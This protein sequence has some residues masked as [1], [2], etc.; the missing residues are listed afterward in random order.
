M[1]VRLRDRLGDNGGLV[2]GPAVLG[3]FVVALD[4]PHEQRVNSF[5]AEA[6]AFVVPDS[7]GRWEVSCDGDRLSGVVSRPQ[8]LDP[9][10]ASSIRIVG[11]NASELIA[12]GG[13]WRELVAQSPL[14]PGMSESADI[15]P[16][17]ELVRAGLGH[18][19]EVC[20]RPRA[21]LRVEVERTLVG[22]ARRVPVHAPT[23][24]AAHTEDWERPTLRSV[25]PRRILAEVREDQLD[26]YENRVAVR[27]V[28][29]LVVY[30]QARVREV[31]RALGA[32]D[33]FNDRKSASNASHWRRK[34]FFELWGA[35]V[36][37]DD[38][39]RRAQRTLSQL[40]GLLAAVSGLK[41]SR[42]YEAVPRRASVGTTLTLTNILTDDPHYRQVAELWRAWARR[43]AA[44]AENARGYYE[45]MQGVCRAFDRFALLL[46]VRGLHQLGFEPSE[47][48]APLS[49]GRVEVRRGARSV[50][51][52]W[53][54]P[55]GS[56][57]VSGD[58]VQALHIVPLCSSLATLEPE[59]L[60]SLVSEA[61]DHASVDTGTVVLFPTPAATRSYDRLPVELARRLRSLT[62]DIGLSGKQRVGFLSASPWDIDSVERVARQLRWVTTAPLFRAF[63]GKVRRLALPATARPYEWLTPSGDEMLVL[64]APQPHE[65]LPAADYVRDAKATL[66]RLEG[67]RE[68]VAAT[69]RDSVRKGDATREKNAQKASLAERI[70]NAE[71]AVEELC[72]FESGLTAAIRL[73]TELLA[74]PI[75]GS[76]ADS[77][78]AFRGSSEH[79]RCK[80][81]HCSSTWET[82]R[83]ADCG[84]TI[85]VLR[86]A[87][88]SSATTAH[89]PGWIDLTLGCDVLAIPSAHSH[90]A[91]YV[92]PSCG[93]N[94]DGG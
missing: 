71:R 40:T 48:D 75:C 14:A 73:A 18:L 91:S 47:P 37:A 51:L 17:D 79:F 63:P 55:D 60:Q 68:A 22:R 92:C 90:K 29:H 10:D 72:Q 3:R 1:S 77:R 87:D 61:D 31:S 85:P 33:T 94:G 76:E 88:S 53:S 58:Y 81:P 65:V 20:R 45:R 84:E 52:S 30:L 21:H 9:L 67:E 59:Q 19:A 32:L 7:S 66:V 74:C 57:R 38:A 34:R 6:G 86:I 5:E 62:H 11:D 46:T 36:D 69:L 27:L 4:A 39:Q 28:D 93:G 43:S 25:V 13:T 8:M 54:S 23:H 26:I 35:S 64:R 82:L 80:C 49:G 24:L 83:C 2:S 12:S 56:I 41:H 16:F 44:G 78:R 50:E 15:Q 70:S 42:L 89:G